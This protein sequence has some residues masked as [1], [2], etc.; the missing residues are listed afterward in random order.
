MSTKYTEDALR[1]AVAQSYSY[2]NVLRLLGL[3]QA[4]GTQSYISTKVKSLGIDTSHFTL[5]AHN[6]GKTSPRRKNWQETLVV[7][8]VGSFRQRAS[9]LRRAMIESGITH[10]CVGCGVGSTWNGKNLTLEV[11][12]IDGDWYN[13]QRNNLRFLC[14]NCH[15]QEADT[16]RSW[17]NASGYG[18]IRQTR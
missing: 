6:K 11:D 13:N 12:H 15:S 4:G 3:K 2:A 7:M 8:P 18:E 16:N 17:K 1:D 5:Q 9:Q 10:E 14:P